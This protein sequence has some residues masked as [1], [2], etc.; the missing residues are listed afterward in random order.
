MDRNVV[1]TNG[2]GE[3]ASVELAQ[4]KTKVTTGPP[5]GEI[6]SAYDPD[7]IFT[8][9]DDGKYF[10][11]RDLFPSDFDQ[12]LRLDGKARTLENVLTLPL[13]SAETSIEPGPG[14][15]GECE[16]VRE[17]LLTAANAGG[18]STPLD[19]VIGQMTSAVVKKR[20]YF[21]KVFK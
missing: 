14:D 3:V 1:L 19:Q 15:S 17:A 10:E 18:M 5:E 11:T 6:G 12:M 13:M 16:F 2:A 8:R 7:R 4:P 21:E 20:A 9:F